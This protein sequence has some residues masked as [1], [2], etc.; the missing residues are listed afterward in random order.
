MASN[1]ER[2]RE[3][4]DRFWKHGDV[5]AGRDLFARDIQWIGL[6][7]ADLG[8][9][10]RGRRAVSDFFVSW[11]DAWDDY[12]NEVEVF[13]VTP[14]LLAS[15]SLFRGR[16]KGSGLEVEVEIGQVWEFEDEEVVRQTMYR[17]YEEAH[18]AALALV[19]G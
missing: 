9:E 19:D 4:F 13:E 1:A 2:L 16:G 15:R 14:D 11:L 10:W 12:S 17:T 18:R 3:M 8:G 6:D 5:G 7:E